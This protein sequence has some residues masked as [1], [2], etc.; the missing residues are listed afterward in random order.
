MNVFLAVISLWINVVTDGFP[1]TRTIKI[2][3]MEPSEG[4]LDS[5]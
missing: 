4:M 5:V 2:L 3:L 1:G